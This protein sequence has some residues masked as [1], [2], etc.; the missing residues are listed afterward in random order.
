[1]H[2][3]GNDIGT[4]G[5]AFVVAADAADIADAAYA[6]NAAPRSSAHDAY[7]YSFPDETTKFAQNT[8]I[9]TCNTVP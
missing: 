8:Q 7:L 2:D 4:S 6:T 3:I 1:M 9:D 5:D